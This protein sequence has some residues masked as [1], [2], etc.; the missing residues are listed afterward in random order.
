MC[1]CRRCYHGM[2]KKFGSIYQSKAFSKESLEPGKLRP[3]HSPLCRLQLPR[4]CPVLSWHSRWI[5]GR[6][7]CGIQ[8]LQWSRILCLMHSM[9]VSGYSVSFTYGP[10]SQINGASQYLT[11]RILVDFV[12]LRDLEYFIHCRQECKCGPCKTRI[13]ARMLH[14]YESALH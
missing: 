10:P 6:P 2:I 5:G 4:S 11:N 7:A 14:P 13:I 12:C 9:S 3:R 8:A 1:F